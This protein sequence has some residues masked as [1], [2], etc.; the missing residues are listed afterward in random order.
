MRPREAS[1]PKGRDKT[2]VMKNISS[3]IFE[4]SAICRT[5]EDKSPIDKLP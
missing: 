1:R 2:K 3:V 4:P 5:I